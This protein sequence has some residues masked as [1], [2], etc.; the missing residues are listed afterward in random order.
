MTSEELWRAKVDSKLDSIAESLQALIRV[1]EKQ[2]AM[3]SAHDDLKRQVEAQAAAMNDVTVLKVEMQSVLH[4]VN[5]TSKALV[6]LRSET[7]NRLDALEAKAE[8]SAWATKS[9]ERAVAF[10]A[11]CAAIVTYF[12][13]SGS[14]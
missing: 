12:I 13:D 5:E 6:E 7:D 2:T 11:V 14:S 1:E 4:S 9:I 3:M 8:R 10:L